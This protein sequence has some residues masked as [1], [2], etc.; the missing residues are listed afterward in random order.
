VV[1]GV[2][3]GGI[4]VAVVGGIV[5]AV[6]SVVAVV[7]AVVSVVAVVVVA[8]H[9]QTWSNLRQRPKKWTVL[10]GRVACTVNKWESSSTFAG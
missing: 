10:L 1:A 3:V 8:S 6:V 4:V 5:V 7:V 9:G 2:V